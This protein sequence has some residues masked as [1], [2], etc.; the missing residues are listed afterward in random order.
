MGG[1]PPCPMGFGV[2]NLTARNSLDMLGE[3]ELGRAPEDAAPVSRALAGLDAAP[4]SRVLAGLD[5]APAS[6]VPRPGGLDAALGP[7]A[8]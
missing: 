7:R 3:K 8:P 6:R 1:F 5:A 2:K 4:A